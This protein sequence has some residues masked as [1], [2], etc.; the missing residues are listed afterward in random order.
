MTLT[1]WSLSSIGA[2]SVYA[3]DSIFEAEQGVKSALSLPMKLLR[4]SMRELTSPEATVPLVLVS[5]SSRIS[6]RYRLGMM[7]MSVSMALTM[8]NSCLCCQIA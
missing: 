2:N 8:K 1:C 7:T 6:S 3:P 5:G 4:I